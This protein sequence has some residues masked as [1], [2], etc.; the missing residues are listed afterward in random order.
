MQPKPLGQLAQH[1]R[2]H[3]AQHGLHR[4]GQRQHTEA[5][6]QPA[7]RVLADQGVLLERRHQ[8]VD[9]GAVD[10]QPIGELG[11]RQAAVRAGQH[12]EC[13]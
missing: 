6:V 7:A 2:G 5:D 11:D 4:G 1:R 9:H 10:R 3:V 13:P 8:A 12:L